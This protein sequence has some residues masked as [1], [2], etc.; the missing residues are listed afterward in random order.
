MVK[1]IGVWKRKSYRPPV[2]KVFQIKIEESIAN[3]STVSLMGGYNSD[4]TP[5]IVDW[6]LD[7]EE[8]NGW[9]M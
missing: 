3:G 7:D 4:Y 6:R 9:E 5:D 8:S 1:K 2:Y